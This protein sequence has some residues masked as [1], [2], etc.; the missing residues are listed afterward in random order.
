MGTVHRLQQ[1]LTVHR[2]F[3]YDFVDSPAPC[4]A[5]GLVEEAGRPCG[6]IAL[7]PGVHIPQEVTRRGF[8]FGH[9]LLGTSQY[10]VAHFAFEFY[11][12][13]TYNAL[14]NPNNHLVRAVLTLMVESG[15]Y[16]FFAIDPNQHV[17]AFRSEIGRETMAGLKANLHRMQ[18]STTTQAQYRKLVAQFN[19]NP[20]PPGRLLSWVCHDN[21]DCLNV[22]GDPLDM[23]PSGQG[24]APPKQRKLRQTADPGLRYHP[25]TMLF[26]IAMLIDGQLESAEEQLESLTQ[27]RGKPHVLDDSLVQR[28]IRLHSEQMEMVPIQREQL[29]RWRNASPS[30][31]QRKEINRLFPLVDRHEAL[32]QESLA[33]AAELETGAID[34]IL[35]IE[36]GELGQAVFEGRMPPPTG[37]PATEA[38]RIRERDAIA[39]VLD[40]RAEELLEAGVRDLDLLAAMG[41][42]LPL[43]YRLME[44]SGEREMNALLQQR[45]G[46]FQFAKLLERV[47]IGI[48]TGEIKVPR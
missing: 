3:I 33:L 25:L 37:V 30:A 35:G 12:F 2:Q 26:T 44:L 16:F 10:E 39:E 18:G 34:A 36:D 40:A 43:F 38:L 11:G 23:T 13:D 20:D 28:I 45:L 6:F 14:V 22:A 47:A 42:Q 31:A 7:R 19:R 21:I 41:A 24:D 8:N 46:L 9:S 29:A 4:F 5:L 1:T 27:A 17:T 48:R 15:D 32:L